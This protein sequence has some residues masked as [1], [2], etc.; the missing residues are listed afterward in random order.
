MHF[1]HPSSHA[2]L[3]FCDSVMRCTFFFSYLHSAMLW[4]MSVQLFPSCANLEMLLELSLMLTGQLLV[5][6]LELADE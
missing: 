6:L 1:L 4:L 3:F 2:E 5:L